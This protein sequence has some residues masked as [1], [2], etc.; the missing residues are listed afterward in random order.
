[1]LSRQRNA[2]VHH[3]IELKIDGTR[4]LEGSG[5]E[6]KKYDEEIRW[7]RRYFSLPYDLAEFVRQSIG[8]VV[9]MLLFDRKPIEVAPAH[10]SSL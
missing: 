9:G 6:R 10:I 4:V 1:M 8:G 5:F 7:L 3:K 2:F